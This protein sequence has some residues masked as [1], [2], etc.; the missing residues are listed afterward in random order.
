M[1]KRADIE[2]DTLAKMILGLIS[3]ILLC[4][5]ITGVVT[6]VIKSINT[7]KC[8]SSITKSAVD[9]LPDFSCK[10]NHVELT[11]NRLLKSV[12]MQEARLDEAVKRDIAGRMWECWKQA[13]AGKMDPYRDSFE[14]V[15][16]DSAAGMFGLTIL[17]ANLYLL[18]DV[19]EFKDVPSFN[20]L[21]FWMAMNKPGA[22]S[23]PYLDYI[24]NRH[25]GE[26]ELK[27]MEK[28]EDTYDT[29]KVYVIAWEYRNLGGS[30]NQTIIFAP[31]STLVRDKQ[32]VMDFQVVMN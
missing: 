2:K 5:F 25:P 30:I 15:S 16:V 20:G 32:S 22:N 13:G 18:C 17:N 27:I 24:S 7:S 14:I 9:G 29:S 31:L 28:Q 19:I 4:I 8:S 12:N 11:K 6:M 23:V 1:N 21:Y 26:E 3:F 10:A